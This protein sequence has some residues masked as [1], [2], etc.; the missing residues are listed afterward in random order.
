[1]K[2]ETTRIITE[3]IQMYQGL[4]LNKEKHDDLKGWL[5]STYDGVLLCITSGSGLLEDD[6][7]VNDVLKPLYLKLWESKKSWV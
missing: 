1:M 7:I 3:G 6:K 2:E 5:R 4:L